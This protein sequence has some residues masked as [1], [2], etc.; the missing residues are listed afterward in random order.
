[1]IIQTI[2]PSTEETLETFTILSDQALQE[3]VSHGKDAQ[4]KWAR[5]DVKTK[6]QILIN[7]STELQKNTLD[8]AKAITLTM[9]KPISQAKQEIEK[10]V[11]LCDYYINHMENF[12]TPQKANHNQENHFQLCPS[13]II[14]A[15][16]PWNFPFAQVFRSAIPN[17][18]L[19]NGYLLSHAP[20]VQ[21]CANIIEKLMIDAGLP[22]G[23]MQS[24]IIDYDQ[25]KYLIHHPF[26]TGVSFTGSQATG[27]IIATHAGQALKKVIL[28]LGGSDPYLVLDDADLDFAANTLVN[29]RFMN[30]GQICTSPKRIIATKKIYSQF[31]KKCIDIAKTFETSDPRYEDCLMGPMARSDLR[32]QLHTQVANS[33]N[34]GANCVM[35]GRLE[36]KKGFY[37][38]PTLLTDIKPGM[39]AFDEEVFGPVISL[40]AANDEAQAIDLAN[41]SNFGLGCGVFSQNTEKAT[42]IITNELDAGFGQVNGTVRS[43]PELPFGGVKGSGFGRECGMQGMQEFANIKTIII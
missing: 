31:Q 21:K 11:S 5:T 18:A 24:L 17:L 15:I 34:L 30:A 29:S 39:P 10:C 3:S 26:V 23:L 7:I 35:G 12:L 1:M 28:E 42:K 38:A 32:Q 19:G 2:N 16:M 37:Y 43:S 6:K 22:E 8:Y 9:G 41:Q 25:A 13:G 40:I 20:N 27:K 4:K 36:E 33:I 14:F